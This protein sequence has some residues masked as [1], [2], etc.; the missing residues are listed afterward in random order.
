MT[1]IKLQMSELWKRICHINSS[2]KIAEMVR[3]RS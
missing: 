2:G 3:H 1:P